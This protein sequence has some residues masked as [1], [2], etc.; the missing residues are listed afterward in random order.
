MPVPVNLFKAF[1]KGVLRQITLT[2]YQHTRPQTGKRWLILNGFLVHITGSDTMLVL[3]K[4]EDVD[5]PLGV[6]VMGYLFHAPSATG[7]GSYTLFNLG[8]SDISMK[9]WQPI[10]LDENTYLA[11]YGAATAL[12]NLQVL[13]WSA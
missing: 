13:E 11:F 3:I 8:A 6:D 2:N 10:I 5:P 12:G 4:G 7:S 9:A 1:E